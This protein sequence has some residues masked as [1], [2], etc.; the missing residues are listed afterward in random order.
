MT[1]P[2]NVAVL[3][4]GIENGLAFAVQR[5]VDGIDLAELINYVQK[6][7]RQIPATLVARLIK[8]AATGVHTIHQA[9]VIHRD[10]KPAN[11]F[12]R[13]NGT[14]TIGDFGISTEANGPVVNAGTPHFMAPEQWNSGPIDRRTDIYALG[15]TTHL[16][17]TKNYP[18]GG[19]NI[20][21]IHNAHLY[22]PYRPPVARDHHE[23]YLF[24]VVKRMLGQ[25]LGA[26]D[27]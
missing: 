2:F 17:T 15:I 19:Q 12:L 25:N 18:C 11:L 26:G 7:G 8:D 13:G 24:G 9:G 4:A 6:I 20:H 21:Q 16:L 14:A 27:K 1:S 22:Q 3:D 10:V 5:Y 23:G